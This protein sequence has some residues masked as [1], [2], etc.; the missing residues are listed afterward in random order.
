[1]KLAAEKCAEIGEMM[2][3]VTDV[4]GY[5]DASGKI[6]EGLEP[7][8]DIDDRYRPIQWEKLFEAGEGLWV[9]QLNFS[10]GYKFA[11]EEYFKSR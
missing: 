10:E 3:M 9:N 6:G 2:G 8:L 5:I 4:A 1:M 7:G 11:V